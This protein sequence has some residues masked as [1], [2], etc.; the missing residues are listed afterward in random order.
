MYYVNEGNLELAVPNPSKG[1]LSK[2][3]S[4]FYNPAAK[5]SR[6]LTLTFLKSINVKTCLDLLSA[7]GA[8][9]LRIAKDLKVHVLLNDVN[10]EAV[11][12]IKKNIELNK[13]KN[14]KV[15]NKSANVLLREIKKFDYID[16]DP[17]G[18]P[19]PFLD[20]AVQKVNKYLA[21]TATDTSA[22]AG[23]YPKA[24]LRKYEALPLKNEFMQETGLRILIKR[25]QDFG[26]KNKLAFIPVFSFNFERYS[27]VF[28]KVEKNIE[29]IRQNTGYIC[30][31]SECL[32]RESSKTEKKACPICK[33]KL[34]CAGKLWI[35]TLWDKKL[36]NKMLKQDL[37]YE[38][39]KLLER[40]NE[41]SKI[42]TIG[43]YDLHLIAKKLKKNV[44]SINDI[45]SNIK[46]EGFE[47]SRTHFNNNSLRSNINNKKIKGL[48]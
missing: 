25:V 16:I 13:I 9:G 43:F 7:S 39:R 30:Y 11:K 8:M 38:T 44:P 36:V 22:L 45:I 41:E 10:P 37:S 29:K 4:V 12:L 27:R 40:I 3:D 28:F 1:T 47:V 31:C 21:V 32:W 5:L 14:A 42:N 26:I 17:F 24:C 18:T 2:K 23:A 33:S 46:K 20:L 34:R 6:E 19:V 15:V 48:F 35:G